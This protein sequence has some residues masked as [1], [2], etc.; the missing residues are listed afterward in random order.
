MLLMMSLALSACSVTFSPASYE[1]DCNTGSLTWTMTGCPNDMNGTVNTGGSANTIQSCS[2]GTDTGAGFRASATGTATCITTVSTSQAIG[3]T[4]HGI[5]DGDG[6]LGNYS[7]NYA[8]TYCAE[9]GTDDTG[10]AITDIFT[11]VIAGVAG[12]AETY[13]LALIALM[14]IGAV[15]VIFKILKI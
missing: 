10:E 3:T 4:T 12:L 7:E 5:I 15:F 9:Y 13:G 6:G 1:G 14:I 2:V 11:G 8:Y